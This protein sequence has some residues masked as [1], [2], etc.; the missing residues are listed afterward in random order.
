[1]GVEIERKFLPSTEA[2]RAV[3]GAGTRYVQAYLLTDPDRTVR[4]RVAGAAAYLTIKGR[5][6][7]AS[8]AEFEYPIPVADA[9]ALLALCP[10]PP[11]EKIRYRVP[12]GAHVFEV[13]EFVGANAGL[14]VI[15]VELA[16]ENEDFPRPLW[17]GDEVTHDTRYANA[18]L[19]EHPF[20]TW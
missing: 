3:V 12:L 4:V 10:R 14:V 17:L 6:H 18:C 20:S 19:I 15:E 8:R 11:V 13:D 7:G 5:T 2:W 16:H 1:M 9:E